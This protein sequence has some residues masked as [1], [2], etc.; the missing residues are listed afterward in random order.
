MEEVADVTCQR[1]F[2]RSA[3][4][5]EAKLFGAVCRRYGFNAMVAAMMSSRQYDELF[6]NDLPRSDPGTIEGDPSA[7]SARPTLE[8]RTIDVF[9]S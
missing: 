3:D 2:D 9:R 1:L 5:D 7:V 6:G 8:R 4:P